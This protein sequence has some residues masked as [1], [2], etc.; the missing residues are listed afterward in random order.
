MGMEI[1]KNTWGLAT[2]QGAVKISLNHLT[3][4]VFLTNNVNKSNISSV[5]TP[6]YPYKLLPEIFANYPEHKIFY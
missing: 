4:A 5:S 2:R 6:L 1:K 3:R